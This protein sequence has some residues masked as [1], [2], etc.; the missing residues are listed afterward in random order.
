M[1]LPVGRRAALRPTADVRIFRAEDGAS[2][3]YVS[4]VGASFDYRV[5]GTNSGRRL[6]LTPSAKARF[7]RVIVTDDLE[8]GVVG[9]EVGLTLGA[10]LGR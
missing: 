9:W 5:A 8:T 3:G 1:R 10:G 7:G 4:S 2:Q 6:V